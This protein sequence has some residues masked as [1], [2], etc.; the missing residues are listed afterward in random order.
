MAMRGRLVI[1]KLSTSHRFK[2]HCDDVLYQC[3]QSKMLEPSGSP[4]KVNAQKNDY[5]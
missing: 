1:S 3:L 4:F 5:F 2:V